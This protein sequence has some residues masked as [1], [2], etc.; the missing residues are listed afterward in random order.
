MIDLPT[1]LALDDDS[2]ITAIALTPYAKEN[3][4]VVAS[5]VI[6]RV[7]FDDD[8]APT[9]AIGA[10]AAFLPA[11]VVTLA[12][13]EPNGSTWGATVQMQQVSQST[14][15]Q[16]DARPFPHALWEVGTAA[17]D[18]A[19]HLTGLHGQSVRYVFDQ[20]ELVRRFEADGAEVHG[21]SAINLL[22]G[23]SIGAAISTDLATLSAVVD[24]PDLP[25]DHRTD[26][27]TQA[28]HHQLREW[29]ATYEGPER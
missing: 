10:L 26:H 25:Y 16:H 23:L 29:A 19:Q 7:R 17:L 2:R 21:W 4:D 11:T 9:E 20:S 6:H 12:G 18:R 3:T 22:V 24:A 28:L 14:K 1:V 8:V 5:F 15:Q 27:V 13:F